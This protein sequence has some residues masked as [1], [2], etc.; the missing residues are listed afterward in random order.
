MIHLE[1]IAIDSGVT[2]NLEAMWRTRLAGDLGAPHTSWYLE[3][4]RMATGPVIIVGALLLRGI[5]E[6]TR[7]IAPLRCDF[8]LNSS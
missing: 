6:P 1:S 7:A 5:D 4:P 2:E 8:Y 3:I